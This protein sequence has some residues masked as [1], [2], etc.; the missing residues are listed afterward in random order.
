MKDKPIIKVMPQG[1][2][3]VKGLDKLTQGDGKKVPVSAPIVLCRCGQSSTKP[4]CDGTHTTLDFDDSKHPDREPRELKTYQGKEVTI[5]DDRGICSHASYCTEGA[6]GVFI[7]E[8][9]PWIDPDGESK[10]T[11]I[12]TIRRCPSGALSYTVDGVK[13]TEFFPEEEIVVSKDGPYEV[14]GSIEL[15]NPDQPTL[16][17]Q[18]VLCRC[19]KS[20][21]HPFCSG[22][23]ADENFRDD[24]TVEK[25]G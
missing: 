24:G 11:I 19:G 15:D 25:E 20:K 17:E 5:H 2:Y 12:N 21:N 3:I 9:S 16:I 13:Y 1:P 23:H 14:R 22:L 18:Y 6:P 4:F 8:N 7:P 10:E